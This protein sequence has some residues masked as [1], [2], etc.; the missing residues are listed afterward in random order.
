MA[1]HGFRNDSGD[2]HDFY[3]VQKLQGACESPFWP[4]TGPNRAQNT[5]NTLGDSVV[6]LGFFYVCLW[7]FTG[8]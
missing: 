7:G 6:V 8:F 4:K 2:F 1:G 3:I 5:A